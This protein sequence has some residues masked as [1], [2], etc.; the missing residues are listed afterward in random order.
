LDLQNLD[1]TATGA[2]FVNDGT[3]KLKGESGQDITDLAMDISSGTV[4]YYGATGNTLAWSPD[5]RILA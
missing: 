1:L 3:L 2:G 4:D 5:M